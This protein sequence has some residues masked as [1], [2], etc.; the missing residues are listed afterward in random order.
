MLVRPA[1]SSRSFATVSH[2]SRH[3]PGPLQRAGVDLERQ[4]QHPALTR[5]RT[6]DRLAPTQFGSIRVTAAGDACAAA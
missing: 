1:G 6:G 2:L 5:R 3:R 4:N